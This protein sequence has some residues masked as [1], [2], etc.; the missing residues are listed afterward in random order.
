[1]VV[2]AQRSLKAW[3]QNNRGL[4]PIRGEKGSN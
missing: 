1:M 3:K 4:V 2:E